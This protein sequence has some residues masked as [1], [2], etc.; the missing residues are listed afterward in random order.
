MHHEPKDRTTALITN[1][2]MR[3]LL[4]GIA[5]R[6]KGIRE[7]FYYRPDIL[8]DNRSTLEKSRIKP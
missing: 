3:E 2:M 6:K 5:M 1:Y 7:P 4:S 8:G